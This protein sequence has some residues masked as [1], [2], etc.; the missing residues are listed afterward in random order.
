[1]E[2]LLLTE[3]DQKVKDYLLTIARQS[4][5]FHLSDKNYYAVL[6]AEYPQLEDPAATFVTL[7]KQSG[8]LRGCIGN[9]QAY[10]ALY[11]SVSHN[12][13]SAAF[14]DPRFT[15]LESH[16][17]P[18]L[19]LSI[20]ILSAASPLIVSSEMELKQKLRPE[21]DGL[22]L[23]A[24]SHNA[25]FLPSVWEDLPGK[26]DFI[27]QLKIKAGLGADY[28]SESMQFSTYQS[29]NFSGPAKY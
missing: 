21:V 10:E 9:L 7:K 19:E 22:I 17:W 25:T 8:I 16:E 18:D 6:P 12:A 23:K 5:E 1:M 3:P 29:Y 2:P 4:I 14:H 11:L 24:G 28:W 27:K 15:A 20:S 13:V 26:S